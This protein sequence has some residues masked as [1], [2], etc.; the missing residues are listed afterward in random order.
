M[1]N[2][3]RDPRLTHTSLADHLA[4]IENEVYI[5][6]RTKD[7]VDSINDKHRNPKYLKASH[8]HPSL[9]AAADAECRSTSLRR[10]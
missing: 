8:P 1:L 9:R 2:D 4:D 3:L 5:W 10:N 6:S 7:V